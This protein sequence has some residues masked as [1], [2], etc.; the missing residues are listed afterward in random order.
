MEV[1]KVDEEIRTLKNDVIKLQIR[2]E[3]AETNIKTVT[4]SVRDIKNNTSKL[5]W[6][7]GSALVLT[8]LNLIIKGGLKL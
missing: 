5:V 6:L 4:E 3:V 1:V 7:V 2:M 8:I